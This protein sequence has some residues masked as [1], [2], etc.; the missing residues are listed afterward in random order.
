MT[1]SFFVTTAQRDLSDARNRE[2]RAII[3]YMKSV[4]DFETAQQAPLQG[5]SGGLLQ[6]AG[7]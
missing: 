3:D 2:L 1:S 4:I 5:G 6:V 7:Q